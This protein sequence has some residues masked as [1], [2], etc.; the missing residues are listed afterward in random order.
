M[1]WLAR[2]YLLLVLG[3]VGLLYIIDFGHYA[4]LGV[5]INATVLRYLDDAQISRQMLWESYPVLWIV[6]A[7]AAPWPCA[8]T[9]CC[10]WNA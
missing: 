1:R 6:L 9:P 8:A 3:G 7:W 4:Y 5:R 2:A 10:A